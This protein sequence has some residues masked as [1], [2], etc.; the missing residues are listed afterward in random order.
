MGDALLWQAIEENLTYVYSE[1]IPKKSTHLHTVDFN[2]DWG[3]RLGIGYNIPRDGWDLGLYWTHIHNTANGKKKAHSPNTL[4]PLWSTAAQ[5]FNGT[6]DTANGHWHVKLNQID[7]NL[8]RQFYIAG[9][10]TLRPFIG[11]RSDW[12]VQEY[13]VEYKGT[14]FQSTSKNELESKLKNRFW[15][16]GFLAGF[17]TDWKLGKGFSIYGDAD[18]SILVGFFDVDQKGILNDVKIWSQDKSFR[19]GRAIL[20]LALGLKWSRF[21]SKNRFG[22]TFKTGYEYHLYF[23]QNQFLLSSGSDNFELFN[24]VKGD[25]TY[26]GVIGSAQFDF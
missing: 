15:G 3:L 24:P 21:F 11:L 1:N 26:Q 10:L 23:N 4:A 17:D 13:D 19:T 25:L 2:W 20:D 8:G 9:F 6:I 16:F 14:A 5:P 7:L 12:I 18:L 22:I